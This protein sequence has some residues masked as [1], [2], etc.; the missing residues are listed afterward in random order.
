MTIS[1]LFK[2]LSLFGGRRAAPVVEQSKE[3]DTG[4]PLPVRDVFSTHSPLRMSVEEMNA[5][6]FPIT[7]KQMIVTD[8]DGKQFAMD[9]GNN[10]FNI[11]S[12]YSVN[13]QRVPDGILGWYV[14]QSFMGFQNCALMAQHWLIDKACRMPAEDAARNG[15]EVAI[16]DGEALSPE[17]LLKIKEADVKYHAMAKAVELTAF[18]RVFGFRIA[19][20][21]IESDDPDYYLKPYNPDGIKKGAFKGI[22]QVDPTWITPEL[23]AES[24][25]DPF[26]LDFYEPT[27]WRVGGR[28]Y[29]KSHL[30]IVRHSEVADILKPSYI[31]G[32]VSLTQQIYERVYA[33]ERTAN[34]APQ[35]AMTKRM[36]V[37]KADLAKVFQNP[38][39]FI[40]RMEEQAAYR[41]NYG[42]RVIDVDEDYTQHETS[43]A[44]LDSVIMSQY[45]LVAAIS[46]VPA[47][48]LL[49]TSPKGFNATGENE[50]QSY[51]EMLAGLQAHDMT[52]L[53]ERY[54]EVMLRSEFGIKSKVDVVWN[55][56]DEPTE[57]QQANINKIKADTYSTLQTTGAIDGQDIRDALIKDR[58]S[59]FNG[60]ESELPVGYEMTDETPDAE[61]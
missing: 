8:T 1:P 45:Q 35:L 31:Y 14:N 47:T 7:P 28:R 60:I 61:A 59:G 34:E 44:D 42:T 32:G 54:Y 36:N 56:M 48:K 24:V 25:N 30:I 15:W 27:Y 13:S 16:N 37:V 12:L 50:T 49:G 22:A 46:E 33:A 19:R 11:K 52:P 51:H 9:D 40:Q 17:L 38:D 53:L 58:S 43:L 20:M 4:R 21:V 41:D 3:L 55:P 10:Q 18:K 57:E 39:R 2:L 6:A 23:D 29:H 5:R 26:G